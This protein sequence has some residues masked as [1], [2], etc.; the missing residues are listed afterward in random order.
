MSGL[1][2][3]VRWLGPKVGGHLALLYIHQVN[4]ANSHNSFAMMI[5]IMMIA[6]LSTINTVTFAAGQQRAEKVY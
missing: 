5:A 3:Q 4:R 1:A 6:I 2:A